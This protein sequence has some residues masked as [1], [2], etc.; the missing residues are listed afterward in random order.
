MTA[1]THSNLPIMY[2]LQI[3]GGIVWTLVA[4][5]YWYRL[6]QI[7]GMTAHPGWIIHLIPAAL[8]FLGALSIKRSD[9]SDL[10]KFA[11]GCLIPAVSV[12]FA[13]LLIW[14]AVFGEAMHKA[15]AVVK[16]ISKYED[17]LVNYWRKYA[18]ELVAHFPSSIPSDAVN[19]KFYFNPHFLQGGANLQLRYT[20]TPEHLET[21]HRHHHPNRTVE[22]D[23]RGLAAGLSESHLIPRPPFF[24]GNS[25]EMYGE[26]PEDFELMYFNEFVPEAAM[27]RREQESEHYWNRAGTHGLAIS[28]KRNEIIFWVENW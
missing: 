5:F 23:D 26:L 7:L 27:V 25:D 10:L 8:M 18:P 21:L 2:R 14:G 22:Y 11:T 1:R 17:R 6:S 3:A 20:T 28:R 9:R 12:L 24:T 16:D 19:P 4:C 15:T 13:M